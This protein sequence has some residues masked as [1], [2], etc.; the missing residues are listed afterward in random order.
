MG[1]AILNNE[2]LWDQYPTWGKG[3]SGKGHVRAQEYPMEMKVSEYIRSMPFLWFKVDDPA[4]KNSERAYLEKNAI[5][6]LSNYNCL[7]SPSAID[8]PSDMWL[9]KCC[10]NE[11]VRKSGLWNV[12]HVSETDVDH[13]FLNRLGARICEM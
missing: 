12:N 1:T 6:L 4:S 5:T 7:G 9:G 3:S 10:S 8:P 11:A 2:G 13:D